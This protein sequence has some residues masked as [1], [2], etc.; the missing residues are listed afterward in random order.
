MLQIFQIRIQILREIYPV[1]VYK[2]STKHRR[3]KVINFEFD[4]FSLR[5]IYQRVLALASCFR[6]P[7]K[8]LVHT[9]RG[10]IYTY[11]PTRFYDAAVS[12]LQS[13]HLQ[14]PRVMAL[15]LSVSNFIG[16]SK[17]SSDC[18][19]QPFLPFHEGPLNFFKCLTR[20]TFQ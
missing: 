18:V 5:V 4:R 10:S 13:R 20:E 12:Q 19:T 2:M 6:C 1:S 16:L 11:I 7:L 8:I 14:L 3:V 9:F 15:A 17:Y